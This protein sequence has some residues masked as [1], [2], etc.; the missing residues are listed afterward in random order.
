M[1]TPPHDPSVD[2]QLPTDPPV[3]DPPATLPPASVPPTA[4]PLSPDAAVSPDPAVVAV[5]PVAPVEPVQPAQPDRPGWL[6][7][8]AIALGTLLLGIVIGAVGMGVIGALGHHGD[9]HGGRGDDRSAHQD[10]RRQSPTGR[11]PASRS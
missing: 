1:T 8:S 3:A 7:T 6:V 2:P 11:S 10:D 4:V 5:A 9:R